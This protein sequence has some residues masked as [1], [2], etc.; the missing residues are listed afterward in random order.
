MC[1]CPRFQHLWRSAQRIVVERVLRVCFPSSHAWLDS[2]FS[3]FGSHVSMITIM[4]DLCFDWP[5]YTPASLPAST[6]DMGRVTAGFFSYTH[7][8]TKILNKLGI[9]DKSQQRRCIYQLRIVLLSCANAIINYNDAHATIAYDYKR[10][11][12]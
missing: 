10:N 2:H 9:V 6:S 3:R 5:S 8:Q 1:V 7:E 11:Y 12:I 4:T